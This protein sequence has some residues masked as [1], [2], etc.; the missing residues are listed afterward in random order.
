MSKSNEVYLSKIKFFLKTGTRRGML[1]K[2]RQKSLFRLQERKVVLSK[3]LNLLGIS[4]ERFFK[5]TTHFHGK[6]SDCIFIKTK[7]LFYIVHTIY[8]YSSFVLLDSKFL[9]LTFVR[10][11]KKQAMDSKDIDSKITESSDL[12]IL[13]LKD[14]SR[15]SKSISSS[16]QVP[17]K[18]TYLMGQPNENVLEDNESK[19]IEQNENPEPNG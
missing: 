7:T 9:P 14:S 13:I 1:G 8:G 5:K 2:K 11:R 18:V 15:I 12:R 17:N 16:S 6:Y 3:T 19:R 10:K 4:S